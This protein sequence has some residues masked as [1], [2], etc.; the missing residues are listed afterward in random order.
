[1]TK[2]IN[3]PPG[4]PFPPTEITAEAII[5]IGLMFGH[6]LILLVMIVLMIYCYRQKIKDTSVIIGIY[7]F[8]LILGMTSLEHP[9]TPFSPM[10][11]IFFLIFQTSLFIELAIRK[12]SE[13]NGMKNR[14]Y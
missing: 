1:M 4:N 5:D 6:I 3:Q 11:E 10:F 13:R 9:H 14:G 2:N 8:S 12:F 7:A